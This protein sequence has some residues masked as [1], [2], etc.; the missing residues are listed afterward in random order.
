MSDLN[1]IYSAVR[2]HSREKKLSNKEFSTQLLD[3]LG[4]DYESKNNGI[5]LKIFNDDEVI[6]FYPSTGLWMVG[7]AKK[8]GV[9]NMLKYMGAGND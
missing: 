4:I 3:K 1:E 8:R 7:K 6:D 5:H 2:E 9:M